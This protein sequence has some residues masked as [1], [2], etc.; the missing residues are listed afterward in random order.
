LVEC[1]KQAAGVSVGVGGK[2]AAVEASAAGSDS[3]DTTPSAS[4][5][6][7][8]SASTSPAS[9]SAPPLS[10]STPLPTVAHL[11]AAESEEATLLSHRAA[12]WALGCLGASGMLLGQIHH[13]HQSLHVMVTNHSIS[14]ALKIYC[15][16][17]VSL[18]LEYFFNFQENRETSVSQPLFLLFSPYLLNYP[19]IQRRD[20]RAFARTL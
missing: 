8:A 5:Q 18:I 4:R 19:I 20:R 10:S 7:S 2:K 13:Q 16:L 15:V 6:S 9:S 17:R 11:S 1:L 12:I 3:T 14:N